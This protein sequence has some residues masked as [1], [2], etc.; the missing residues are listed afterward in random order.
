MMHLLDASSVE[1][2]GKHRRK[3]YFC[4]QFR[5]LKPA[6]KNAAVKKLGAC[7]RCLE[8]HDGQAFCKPTFLCKHPDCKDWHRPEHH[9]YLC[10]NAISMRN[11]AALKR[12]DHPK[13]GKKGYTVDQEDFISKLPAE[14]AKQC[15]NVFSN[16]ASR[17]LNTVSEPS[18][19]LM[20]YGL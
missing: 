15:R 3:L 2:N 13:A 6:E 12:N 5:A 7:E 1:N 9:Y 11:T 20:Q 16:S 4:K 18:S 10:F 19:L 14:L 8:L 17:M